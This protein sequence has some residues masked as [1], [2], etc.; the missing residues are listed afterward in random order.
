M[1]NPGPK[2]CPFWHRYGGNDLV[3]DHIEQHRPGGAFQ[4]RCKE[5]G[6]KGP[7]RNSKPEAIADWNSRKEKRDVE[8]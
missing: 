5:C 3:V 1:P 8:S 6:A 4:V 7:V 2:P